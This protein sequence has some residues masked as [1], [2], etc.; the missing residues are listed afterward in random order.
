MISENIVKEIKEYASKLE[1]PE[2]KIK[3]FIELINKKL[4]NDIVIDFFVSNAKESYGVSDNTLQFNIFTDKY[5]FEFKL[6][7]LEIYY[8]II[9][10]DDIRLS[11]LL[12]TEKTKLTLR[13]ESNFQEVKTKIVTYDDFKFQRLKEFAHKVEDKIFK[14]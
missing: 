14:F 13:I 4:R 10:I 1:I 8:D 6:N 3:N 12:E 11:G 9:F 5:F 7:N 2:V